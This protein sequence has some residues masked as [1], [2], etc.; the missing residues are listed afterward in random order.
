MVFLLSPSP[1]WANRQVRAYQ[2][3]LYTFG[4]T[5][6]GVNTPAHEVGQVP[7]RYMFSQGR[8]KRACSAGSAGSGEA[9]RTVSFSAL[10]VAASG[11]ALHYT[12]CVRLAR[13]WRAER[14]PLAAN[15]KHLQAAGKVSRPT[16]LRLPFAV[17]VV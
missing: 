16:W 3:A 4:L 9:D 17:S 2:G 14:Q 5:G 10:R 1:R 15:G 8:K 13:N 6:Y 11:L 7:A 12:V